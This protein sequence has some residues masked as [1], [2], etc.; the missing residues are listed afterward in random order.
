MTELQGKKQELEASKK[1]KPAAFTK[2]QQ[3]Q[4]DNIVVGIVDVEEAI[5][6]LKALEAEIYAKAKAELEAEPEEKPY[7][8]PAGEEGFVHVKLIK[9]NLFDKMT[10]K[11]ITTAHVQKFGVREFEAFQ[12]SAH[13]LGYTYTVLHQPKN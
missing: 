5:D 8:V 12:A 3:E 10:G 1:A 9:G 2:E 7:E 13:V 4:L 11:P 6:E